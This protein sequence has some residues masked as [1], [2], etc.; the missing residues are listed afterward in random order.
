MERMFN[1]IIYAPTWLLIVIGLVGVTLGF[2]GTGFY[3]FVGF[4]LAW[5]VTGVPIF[6]M[7]CFGYGLGGTGPI[8]KNHTTDGFLLLGVYL[9]WPVTLLWFVYLFLYDK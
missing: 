4:A 3:S 9:F 7:F 8:T 6:M 2:T 5:L 1:K